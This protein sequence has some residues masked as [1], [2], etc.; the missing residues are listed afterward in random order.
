MLCAVI[1]TLNAESHIDG[2]LNDLAQAELTI[3]IADGGSTDKTID[4]AIRAG[5]SLALGSVGR[6]TQLARGANWAMKMVEPDWYLFLHADSRLDKD[7]ALAVTLHMNKHADKVGYFRFRAAAK[8]WKPRLMEFCVRFRELTF[9]APYG[10]QGLLISRE[11]YE[12]IGGYKNVPLFED[13][14]II[15]A[16]ESKKQL[17]R[18]PS[19]IHTDVSCY[20]RDGYWART[21]RNLR[22]LKAYRQGESSGALLAEY[23]KPA[24]KRGAK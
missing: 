1:P 19:N 22:L 4:M 15:E 17:R 20:E 10:D 14:A 24:A 7:W 18:L 11:L 16:L 2:L 8:G 13:V 23:T 5:A 9:G 21:T 12:R 3:V 6:G